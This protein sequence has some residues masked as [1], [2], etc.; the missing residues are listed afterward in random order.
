MGMFK[1]KV[2]KSKGSSMVGKDSVGVVVE[3]A[4][5]VPHAQSLRA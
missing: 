3:E 5:C 4:V 2:Y 1:L